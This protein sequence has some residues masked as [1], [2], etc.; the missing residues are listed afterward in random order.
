MG[1][2]SGF[3]AGMKSPL[4]GHSAT[5]PVCSGNRLNGVK[6]QDLNKI[7]SRK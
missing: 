2:R 7:M 3:P 5:E 6:Q 1:K 4:A